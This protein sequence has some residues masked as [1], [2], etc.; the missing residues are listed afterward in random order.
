[1]H[2][3]QLASTRFVRRTLMACG[4]AAAWTLCACNIG[5]AQAAE[6]VDFERDIAPIFRQYCV[7]CHN[8]T[9]P[10]KGLIL[11]HYDAVL[12]GGEGGAVL[13]AG[14]SDQSRLVLMLEGKLEPAMPPPDNE[15][16]SAEQIALIKAWID[17]GA[18]GPKGILPDPTRLVTPKV[19]LLAPARATINAAAVSPDG[20]LGALA[21]H[22]EVRIIAMHSRD[23]VN[24]LS[25]HRGSVT[26]VVFSHDGGLLLA[27]AGEPGVFGEVRIWK[28]PEGSLVRTIVGHKDSLY[29]VAIA[30]AS[31]IVATGGYDQQIK[32]WD[33]ASGNELRTL[34]GHNGAIFDL[35]FNRA[36]TILASASADRTVKLWDVATGERLDTFGQPLKDQYTVSFSPDGSHVAAGGADNRIRV[37]NV[38]ESGKD[39]TNQ[40]L[41]TRFAHE[42]AILKLAYSPDGASL[43]SSADDRTV[44][45][46]NVPDYTERKLLDP[47]SDWAP[48]LAVGSDNKTLLAGRQDG[49]L[50]FYDVA[51]GAVLP[52]PAPQLIA[53]AP[54][55]IQRGQATRLRLTGEG[56]RSITKVTIEP[57]TFVVGA[58]EPMTAGGDVWAEISPAPDTPRGAYQVKVHTA[59]GASA[60]VTL[61]VDDLPQLAETE[62]NSSVASA[63]AIDLPSGVWGAL[64]TL[65]DED[66]FSFVARAGQ[67]MVFDVAMQRVGG[68]GDA[69][70]TLLDE[71]GRVVAA[72][73]NDYGK[74]EPLL[75]HQFDA[76]G[77]YVIRVHDL[78]RSGSGGHYYRLTAGE[79]PYV[80]GC[81]PL[82][83]PSA[84]EVSVD[85]VGFNLPPHAT[86]T[87][88]AGEAGERSLP[89]DALGYRTSGPVN[90]LAEEL[91][92]EDTRE[93]EPNDAPGEATA[94]AVPGRA[95]GRIWPTGGNRTDVDLFKVELEAGRNVMIEAVAAR[96]GSP[97]DS[98]IEVLDSEGR[99]VPRTVLQAVRDSYIEFR[100]IDSNS[101][102]L[103]PKNWEEMELNE[104][105]YLQGEIVK[106]F[107]MPQGPDSEVIF[108]TSAGKRRCYFDT[109]ATNHALEENIYTIEPHPPGTSLVPN[110]L[111][112]FTL[113]YA[114]DDDGDRSAGTDSRLAF[115]APQTGTYLVR[116]T[117]VRGFRGDRFAYQLVV[118]DPKPGFRVQLDDANPSLATGSGRRLTFSALREDGFEGPIR[119][120]IGGLPAGITAMSPVE[121]EAGHSSA[122]SVLVA[123]SDA[124][125][126]SEDDW[127]KVTVTATALVGGES[128]T[129]SVG[130]LGKI[131][132]APSTNLRVRVEPAEITVAPGTSV[133][134]LLKLERSGHDDLVTLDVDNLPHGVIV[135]NIGLNGVLIPA[136][137]NERMIRIT[138]ARWVPDTTRA[139]HAVANNTG[140]QASPPVTLNVRKVETVAQ[141]GN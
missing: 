74:P 66:H 89:I 63:S 67:T 77:R 137:E 38:S 65:G 98:R 85:L 83:V 114:N 130:N 107:R 1:M 62:P 43:V 109:S 91:A 136:G 64:E 132:V 29:A 37:W 70:L 9:E 121:I 68:A 129:Q 113:N 35:D 126:P 75:A 46:W 40:I 73:N 76:D 48:A 96:R 105:M 41:L 16:P 116:V 20:K 124:S 28:M 139:Y 6:P 88:P 106:I 54:R 19:A 141:A 117:D 108:Y 2:D 71:H 36:G 99:P 79:L 24:V 123:G 23:T 112:I 5:L 17:A 33:L 21:M 34:S 61:W 100:P 115:T 31:A 11:E 84:S 97:L 32:L 127:K 59:G 110:G 51:S 50:E 39:G 102:G 47:Q 52:P 82:V 3:S 133:T 56:L 92:V 135:D 95:A 45:V 60:P 7:G 80:T 69:V 122:R 81:Y 111:P 93:A 49:S 25:G 90:V 128:I 4:L 10:E 140:G 131:D 138:A 118:R 44:R 14:K 22:G 119:I 12:A 101:P 27:A 15:A 13:V 8:S 18:P 103:R 26:D 86:L 125:A 55:G 120:D 78:S 42:G 134:A 94:V 53:I 58:L 104:W 72:T 87:L 57:G 30:P